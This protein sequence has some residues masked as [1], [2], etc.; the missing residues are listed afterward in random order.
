MSLPSKLPALAPDR[1]QALAASSTN[2]ASVFSAAGE[3]DV[4]AALAVAESIADL[5]VQFDDPGI[6]ARIV[7][8]QDTPLG[9]RT[10]RDPKV[11]NRK[12][13]RPNVPYDY[14]TVK[15]CTI[16]AMLRGLQIVG[17]Q[18]NIISS[19]CYLTKE[20]LEYL[21][22]RRKDVTLFQI[23]LGVPRMLTGGALIQGEAS[24]NQNGTPRTLKA[25]LP[26]KADQ[27]SGA[28]QILGKAT[29]KL[30]ARCYATMTGTSVP[31][32]DAEDAD[33]APALPPAGGG[34]AAAAATTEAL[35]GTAPAAPRQRTTPKPAAAAPVPTTPATPAVP[36]AETVAPAPPTEP[37]APPVQ[38]T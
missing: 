11:M 18:F 3:G 19:R 5:R 21:I 1:L 28:D 23:T 25:E 36:P 9:F 13:E 32:G 20:G 31:E 6:R 14:E 24:W 8:L 7:A 22:R 10:D 17:N 27:Y 2:A 26:V 30:L 33:P 15:D 4:S 16:E 37:E 38:Q 34:E 29:R 35:K 12:T